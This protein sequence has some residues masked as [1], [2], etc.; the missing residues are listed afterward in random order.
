MSGLYSNLNSGDGLNSVNLYV[1]VGSTTACS[2][3]TVEVLNSNGLYSVN[4][5]VVVGS[6]T[7]CSSVTVEVLNSKGL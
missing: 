1:V 6:T 2:S 3:V 5:Y 7:V 4:L